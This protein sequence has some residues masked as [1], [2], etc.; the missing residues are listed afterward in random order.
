MAWESLSDRRWYRRLCLFYKIRNH[1]TPQYLHDHLPAI[2][3]VTYRIRSSKEFNPPASSFFLYCIS[4]WEKL[5]DDVKSLPSLDQFKSK[6]LISI[7]P[8]ERLMYGI[9][10]IMDIKLF[11]KLRVEFSDLAS[12]RFFHNFDC[13]IC[14][15]EEEDNSHYFIR[16]PR[17]YI[18]ASTVSATYQE[19]WAQIVL[20]FHVII[21]LILFYVGPMSTTILF[22][23]GPMSTTILFYM[24][25]MSTTILFYMGPMSTTILFYM[26]PMSTTILF[27]MGP[28][29]TTI[30]F[31]M[32]PMS[33]TILLTNLL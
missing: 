14:S 6:L 19:L 29:S 15:F 22:Y 10:A 25:P 30:L 21:W 1:D 16:C 23:M 31:Y 32:G 2:R 13:I 20:F 9:H 3:E 11:T 18:F 17:F 27:Y 4:E 24:G 7:H 26:G 12:H 5:S 8:P 33:T 28:M